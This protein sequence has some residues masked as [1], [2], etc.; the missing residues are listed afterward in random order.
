MLYLLLKLY[1]YIVSTFED[2]EHND[3]NRETSSKASLIGSAIAKSDFIVALEVSITCFSY[4]LELS[5]LLQCK[6]QACPILWQI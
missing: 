6:Q 2:L 3:T 5:K 1:I 4:T